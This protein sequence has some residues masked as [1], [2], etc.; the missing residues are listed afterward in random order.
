MKLFEALGRAFAGAR[1]RR[2]RRNTHSQHQRADVAPA[3]FDALAMQ[4]VA[5]HASAHERMLQVKTLNSMK[6][7]RQVLGT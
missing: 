4:L 3:G 6:I 5:Q 1:L 7:R 2:Q